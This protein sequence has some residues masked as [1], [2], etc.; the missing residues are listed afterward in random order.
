MV[1]I[2][3]F[4]TDRQKTEER[5]NQDDSY[6]KSDRGEKDKKRKSNVTVAKVSQFSYLI[7]IIF[8]FLCFVMRLYKFIFNF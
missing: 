4:S 5:R 1:Y 3:K 2:L 7:Y 6:S 8:M